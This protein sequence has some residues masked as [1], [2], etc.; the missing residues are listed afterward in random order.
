MTWSQAK[1]S[2][3][4]SYMIR[5]KHGKHHATPELIVT[6]RRNVRIA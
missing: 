5:R 6:T 2:L 3:F 4:I 1:D